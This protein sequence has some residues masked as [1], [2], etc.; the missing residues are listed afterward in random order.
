MTVPT[1][2][3]LKWQKNYLE[4]LSTDNSSLLRGS[5][6]EKYNIFMASFLKI[7]LIKLLSFPIS[8]T[9]L[10]CFLLINIGPFIGSI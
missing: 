7:K 1:P 6:Q 9:K 10:Q 3:K 4:Y 2:I 8:Y 5:G